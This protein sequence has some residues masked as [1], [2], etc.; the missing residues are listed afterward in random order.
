LSDQKRL[1][2]GPAAD[3]LGVSQST[4]A[5]RRMTGDGPPYL[6]LG[7]TIVYDVG[8]LDLYAEA[9]RRR[10]TSDPGPARPAPNAQ[11]SQKNGRSTASR[12]QE[13]TVRRPKG[14]AK[15]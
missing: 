13:A 8:D 9:H 3:Y 12:Q 14:G 4:L 15:R 5:K 6:K 11:V 7:K 1:R 2:A 10:S